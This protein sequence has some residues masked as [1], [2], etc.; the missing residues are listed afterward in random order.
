MCFFAHPAHL[1]AVSGSDIPPQDVLEFEG[2]LGRPSYRAVPAG[3]ADE[4][5]DRYR[6]RARKLVAYRVL[7]VLV[8]GIA[9]TAVLLRFVES[10]QL[11]GGAGLVAIVAGSLWQLRALD[12]G[13]PEVVAREVPAGEVRGEY[14]VDPSR[15]A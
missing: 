6:S 10:L 9:G 4:V 13:V 12:Q 15:E 2:W 5:V 1:W 11:A 14:G 7:A 8:V 3:Q